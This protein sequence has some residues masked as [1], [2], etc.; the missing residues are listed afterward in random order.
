M[1]MVEPVAKGHSMGVSGVQTTWVK[2]VSRQ[3]IL[4]WGLLDRV[5]N[6]EFIKEQLR[7]QRNQRVKITIFNTS[8]KKA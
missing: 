3:N 6:V 8:N 4:S 5:S 2:S 1:R 7:N